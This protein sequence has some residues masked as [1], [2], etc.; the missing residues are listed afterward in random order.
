MTDIL[1]NYK[2]LSSPESDASSMYS[3]ILSSNDTDHEE[4]NKN[5]LNKEFEFPKKN[6]VEY[7]QVANPYAGS[8]WY[9]TNGEKGSE[10]ISKI[11]E[12]VKNSKKRNVDEIA[13]PPRL[14]SLAN[15]KVDSPIK[16]EHFSDVLG[17]CSP[18]TKTTTEKFSESRYRRALEELIETE[19][20]YHKDLSLVNTVYRSLLHNSRKYKNILNNGEEAVIFG[21]IDTIVEVS[22]LLSRDLLKGIKEKSNYQAIENATVKEQIAV[23][24]VESLDIGEILDN[25]VNRFKIAYSSYFQNHKPQMQ[26]L[27]RCSNFSGPKVK[28]WLKECEFLAKSQSDCWSFES[29]LI[30]PIQRLP[31]Y[32]LLIDKLLDS[33]C[34]DVSF[35]KIQHLCDAKNHLEQLL[36]RLNN[37]SLDEAEK[38]SDA[39][40]TADIATHIRDVNKLTSSG[41]SKVTREEYSLIV[42]EFK[43][44]YIKLQELR[45]VI[46]ENLPYL[47]NFIDNHLKFAESWRVFMEYGD[48]ETDDHFIKSIYSSYS[49]KL[50]DQ[51]KKTMLVVSNINETIVKALDLSIE[52]CAGVKA[53]VNRHNTH[54][55]AYVNYI[56]KEKHRMKGPKTTNKPFKFHNSEDENAQE[57]VVIENQILDEVPILNEHLDAL[58]HYTTLSYH[59]ALSEWLKSLSGERQ[60]AQI[61]EALDNGD[62]TLGNN[63]DIIELHEIS[64]HHTKMALD[65][66]TTGSEFSRLQSP[67][68]DKN[69]DSCV[70]I[71]HSKVIRRL[72]GTF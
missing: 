37:V 68:K 36:D 57:Y 15:K 20:K 71:Y 56:N 38:H 5:K 33:S 41:A 64:R 50:Q 61:K 4:V 14:D 58:L 54:R 42:K 51:K 60:L 62:W 3:A 55:A 35:D 7:Y 46:I 25:Y 65:E 66:F 53:K 2:Y 72:F 29:L 13:L 8:L 39:A 23:S 70:R 1:D 10:A 26:E 47:L 17:C 52:H 67:Y 49:E 43:I 9:S 40:E 32:L 24:R 63:M 30:K 31:K 18:I 48:N 34:D 28:K 59:R 11:Q 12:R 27:T 6:P 69:V 44:K 16:N 21:N 22:H 45:K 19:I